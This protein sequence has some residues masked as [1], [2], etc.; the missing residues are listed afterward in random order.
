MKKYRVAVCKGPDCRAGGADQVYAALR[1][2]ITE[3]NLQGRCEL[4]R[5]GCYGL[6]ELGPNV[7]IREGTQRP[8]DPLSREDFQLTGEPGETHYGAMTE[9]R[10]ARVVEEHIGRDVKVPA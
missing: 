1:A 5:G 3:A 7:V 6:C 4:Y 8:K 10:A 9:E 2:R